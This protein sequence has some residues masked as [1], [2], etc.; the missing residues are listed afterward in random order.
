MKIRFALAL[1][2]FVLL[3]N[4][5]H[6]AALSLTPSDMISGDLALGGPYGPS[7]CEVECIN[8][9]FGTSLTSPDD[10]LYKADAASG[11]E[12]GSLA[13]SY[14]TVFSGANAALTYTGGS[15]ASC[16][17]CYLAVKDG[18]ANPDYYFYNLANWNG[19]DAITLTGFWPDQGGFSHIS[20]WG[21]PGDGGD[22]ITPQ[23]AP[24]PGSIFLVGSALALVARRLRRQKAVQ[25]S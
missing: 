15:A 21:T 16:P 12:E 13:G 6:A 2:A 19:T 4:V 20:I 1:A 25:N 9:V 5:Q 14:A 24:E 7:N 22:D 10:L 8:T 18:N 17:E 11:G 23:A 3:G